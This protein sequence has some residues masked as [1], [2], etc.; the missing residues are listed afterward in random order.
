MLAVVGRQL[1]GQ[2]EVGDVRLVVGV[3]QD[4]GRLQVAVQDALLVGVLDGPGDGDAGSAAAARPGSGPSASCC[5]RLRP[6]MKSMREVVP[7][8]DGADLVDL[9]DV[10]VLQPAGGAGLGVEALAGPA[11][12]ARLPAR[13][14]FRATCAVERLLDGAL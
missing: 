12:P 3:E 13:I 6:S 14:I 5:A 4:V 2:A 10:R 9:D 8:V 11:S 7:A 1:L